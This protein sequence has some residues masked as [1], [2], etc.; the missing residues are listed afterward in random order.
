MHSVAFLSVLQ[1]RIAPPGS[2]QNNSPEPPHQ[3]PM[4]LPLSPS[5]SA[6]I[7]ADISIVQPAS[8]VVGG[9]VGQADY[10]SANMAV[11]PE[12]S[13]SNSNRDRCRFRSTNV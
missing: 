2:E 13:S 3:A 1:H 8:R 4:S 7:H 9:C 11:E 6:W 5:L 12:R 10:C